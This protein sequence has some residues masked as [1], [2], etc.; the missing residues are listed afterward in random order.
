MT[1]KKTNLGRSLKSLTTQLTR[2]MRPGKKVQEVTEVT[3][4]TEVIAKAMPAKEIKP[5]PKVIRSRPTPKPKAEPVIKEKPIIIDVPVPVTA[6]KTETETEPDVVE[7][8]P[9]P[10]SDGPASALLQSFPENK[11]LV[12]QTEVMFTL[13][14]KKHA[15]MIR[16]DCM[17]LDAQKY[18]ITA[19]GGALGGDVE[20][21]ILECKRTNDT[22]S[23]KIG[24]FGKDVIIHLNSNEAAAMFER[25]LKGKTSKHT[26]ERGQAIEIARNNY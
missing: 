26:A 15:L 24:A 5:K 14:D 2:W 21:D 20:L 16:T 10:V 17:Y 4:G 18:I 13:E 11:N 9:E 6:P 12:G 19:S 22:L 3:D 1:H 25:L 7:A 23:L 8:K